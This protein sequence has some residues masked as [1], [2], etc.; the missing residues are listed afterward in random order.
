MA[1]PLLS[2]LSNMSDE[3]M[4]PESEIDS[5]IRSMLLMNEVNPKGISVKP[6]APT[7]H[8]NEGKE[9]KRSVE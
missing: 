3:A 1:N 7:L 6:E 9:M 5:K 8:S 2:E 4:T